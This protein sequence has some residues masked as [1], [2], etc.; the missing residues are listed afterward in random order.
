MASL[1]LNISLFFLVYKISEGILSLVL[2]R[3]YK[4]MFVSIS[5]FLCMHIF[6]PVQSIL[7]L[8]NL[9]FEILVFET[10]WSKNVIFHDKINP[11]SLESIKPSLIVPLHIERRERA[12]F[13][14]RTN[15]RDITILNI[16]HWNIN[17]FIFH[18]PLREKKDGEKSFIFFLKN[19]LCW[20]L[21]SEYSI[22]LN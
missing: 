9:L 4:W 12:M 6:V 2:Q 14:V 15:L 17:I 13:R 19:A 5:R 7:F 1:G 8:E 21:F 18:Q 22:F 16:A 11:S 3:S 20:F 10:I